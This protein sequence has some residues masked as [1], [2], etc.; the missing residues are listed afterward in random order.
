MPPTHSQGTADDF[1]VNG[2]LLTESLPAK[3]SIDI[4]MYALFAFPPPFCAMG[5]KVDFVYLVATVPGHA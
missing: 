2:Q 3:P 1:L 5:E 4:R